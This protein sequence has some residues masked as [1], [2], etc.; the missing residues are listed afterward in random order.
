MT[1][2]E[3]RSLLKWT[4]SSP[5]GLH[6]LMFNPDVVVF[7]HLGWPWDAM[8]VD[9]LSSRTVILSVYHHSE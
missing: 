4:L 7:A 2:L 5:F 3:T 6:P 8:R 1:V 9:L